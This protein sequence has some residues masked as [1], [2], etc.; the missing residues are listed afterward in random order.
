MTLTDN[1][2]YVILAAMAA[3]LLVGYATR[4]AVLAFLP[5]LTAGGFLA[6]VFSSD[7]LYSRIPEDVQ[8]TIVYALSLS[9]AMLLTGVVIRR[10]IDAERLR[11][12]P[13][14]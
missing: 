6:F 1:E 10:I 4:R 2:G 7:D 8:A 13:G 14:T 9:A 11:R 12:R 5:L 3:G